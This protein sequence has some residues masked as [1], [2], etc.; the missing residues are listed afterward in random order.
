MILE[1]AAACSCMMT[2][3]LPVEVLSGVTHAVD[4]VIGGEVVLD[5]L[6]QCKMVLLCYGRATTKGTANQA[7]PS[8]AVHLHPSDACM[9]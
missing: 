7:Y 4:A 3:H 6:L 8:L 2:V 5:G 1:K 9:C